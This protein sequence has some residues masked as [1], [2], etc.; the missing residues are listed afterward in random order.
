MHRSVAELIAELRRSN[1][2]SFSQI[3]EAHLSALLKLGVYPGHHS[4]G[5]NEGQ[6]VEDLWHSLPVHP[7]SL[8]VPVP[9]ADGR[10]QAH[11]DCV[12]PDALGDV[13]RQWALG[14]AK[15]LVSLQECMISIPSTCLACCSEKRLPTTDRVWLYSLWH[16]SCWA[17][18]C[19]RSSNRHK[20][21]HKSPLAFSCPPSQLN[22]SRP[23]GEPMSDLKN[24]IASFVWGTASPSS[25]I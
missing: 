14:S 20:I 7:E 24:L 16:E 6:P 17:R 19:R 2:K 5:G 18:L 1:V 25:G 8:D 4:K 15:S 21:V 3:H 11:S 23:L 13:K 22:D 12:W 10:F 9:T